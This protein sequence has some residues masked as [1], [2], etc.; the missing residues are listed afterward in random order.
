MKEREYNTHD[1]IIS[2][3]MSAFE[4]ASLSCMLKRTIK[5]PIKITLR[6]LFFRNL[7]AQFCIFTCNTVLVTSSKLPVF[8][9]HFVSDSVCYG[10]RTELQQRWIFWDAFCLLDWAGVGRALTWSVFSLN[11]FMCSL[12]LEFCGVQMLHENRQTS[13]LFQDPVFS[14]PY[15]LLARFLSWNKVIGG[16]RGDEMWYH[17]HAVCIMDFSINC[18]KH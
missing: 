6:Q 17:K 3:C 11:C 18:E 8:T 4:W 14:R 1:I 15:Y 13:F 7:H 9:F 12:L 10:S 16:G 2:L 5:N